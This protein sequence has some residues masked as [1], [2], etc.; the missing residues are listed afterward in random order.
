[1]GRWLAGVVGGGL[2][3]ACLLVPVGVAVH[4]QQQVRNFHVVRAGVLYRSAQMTVPGLRRVIHDHGI[5]TVIN[6]RD[7][8]APAD[9]AEEAFCGKEEVRFV[10]LL[11]RSWD[12]GAGAAPVD[13]NMRAFLELMRDPANYP[14]L[15]HCFAGI[16]RTGAYCAVYRMEFEGWSND[17]A[18]GELKAHGYDN[19]DNE[20]DISGYLSGYQPGRLA[21][22]QR[23]R[24]AYRYVS[25]YRPGRVDHQASR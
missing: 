19:F 13:A 17:Q 4:E 1:M 25:G 15:V 3:A 24:E 7:G 11:P 10:R 8:V 9:R 22:H 2:V 18:I 21:R 12:G 6:L 16:H 14:V 23:I 20:N 5:R